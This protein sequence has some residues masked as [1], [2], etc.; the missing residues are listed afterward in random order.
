MAI[1]VPD[2]THCC[3][4]TNYQLINWLC[5]PQLHGWKSTRSARTRPVRRRERRTQCER[6]KTSMFVL[7]REAAHPV[8]R[9]VVRGPVHAA[10]TDHCDTTDVGAMKGCDLCDTPFMMSSTRDLTCHR[11]DDGWQQHP[12]AAASLTLA[13]PATAISTSAVSLIARPR[14]NSKTPNVCTITW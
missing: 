1:R 5:R 3:A 4:K 13:G 10:R 7:A 14:S 9:Q 12:L 6:N 2:R 11:A 8:V